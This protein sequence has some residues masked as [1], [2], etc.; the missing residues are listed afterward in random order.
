MSGRLP[1]KEPR[2]T[3]APSSN[4]YCR[5]T[6]WFTPNWDYSGQDAMCGFNGTKPLFPI[7]TLKIEAGSDIGFGS[8]GQVGPDE[9]KL[10]IPVSYIISLSPDRSN[11][12]CT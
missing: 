2:T 4:E 7:K 6:V 3:I 1:S 12:T 5:P 8:A 10:T 11:Y 9:S